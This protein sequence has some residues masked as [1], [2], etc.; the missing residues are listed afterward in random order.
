M[1]KRHLSYGMVLGISLYLAFQAGLYYRMDGYLSS[2]SLDSRIESSDNYNKE[3]EN[4]GL[5]Y[6]IS[7]IGEYIAVRNNLNEN[8]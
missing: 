5:T 1:N 2:L 8:N 6:K 3:W 7:F 4:K